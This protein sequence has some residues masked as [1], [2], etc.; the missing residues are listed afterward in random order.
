MPNKHDATIDDDDEYS[1]GL[2]VRR[3]T[4]YSIGKQTA[5][6]SATAAVDRAIACALKSRSKV[7]RYTQKQL[8]CLPSS[9]GHLSLCTYLRELDLASNQLRSLPNEIERLPSIVICNLGRKNQRSYRTLV[10]T[11][12]IVY[13]RQ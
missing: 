4:S 10:F 8:T 12:C 11:V 13:F 3:T 1:N 5:T 9:I 6:T 2:L 7:F